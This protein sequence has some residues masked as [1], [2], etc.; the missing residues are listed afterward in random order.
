MISP[1]RSAARTHACMQVKITS[2]TKH[3][4]MVVEV[5]PAAADASGSVI[6]SVASHTFDGL[7]A[8]TCATPAATAHSVNLDHLPAAADL[9]GAPAVALDPTA[10]ERAFVLRSGDEDWG[11][12]IG[13]CC[14]ACCAVDPAVH[15]SV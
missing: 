13:A 6:P 12:V 8:G 11:I 10:A 2:S 14:A 1:A 9:G 3:L 7:A 5:F 15:R 4:A